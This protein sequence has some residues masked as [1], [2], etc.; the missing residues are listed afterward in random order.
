M[1]TRSD[2]TL[3]S[4]KSA[5][6]EISPTEAAI[7]NQRLEADYETQGKLYKDVVHFSC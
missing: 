3:M 6:T 4:L 1:A 2:F 5:F 7:D